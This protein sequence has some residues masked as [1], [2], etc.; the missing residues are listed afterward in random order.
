[1]VIHE[2]GQ[3][4]GT[5]A[6]S[7]C[8]VIRANHSVDSVAMGGQGIAGLACLRLRVI[9]VF[10]IR[11]GQGRRAS[12]L[13]RGQALIGHFGPISLHPREVARRVFH[14][15]EGDPSVQAT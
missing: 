1:M 3:G 15:H 9:E 5:Y 2:S 7:T 10:R 12:R 8:I 14:S 4:A 6:H 13:M 11:L